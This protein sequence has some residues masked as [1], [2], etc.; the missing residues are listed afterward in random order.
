MS[1]T[2]TLTEV[3]VETNWVS[4]HGNDEGIRLVKVDVDTAAYEQGHIPGAIA[5]NWTIQLCGAVQRDII[6]KAPSRA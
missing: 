3:L 6:I 2:I 5:W 4:Q 1:T